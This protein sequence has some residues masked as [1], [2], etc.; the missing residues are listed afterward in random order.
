MVYALASLRPNFEPELAYCVSAD[1]E[2]E[3]AL[4]QSVIAREPGAEA[5]FVERYKKLIFG[6]ARK[7]FRSREED[8]KDVFQKTFVRLWE[9][10]HRAL[11]AWRGD[12]LFSTYLVTIVIHVCHEHLR[13]NSKPGPPEPMERV[14]PG[15]LPEAQVLSMERNQAVAKCWERLSAGDRLMLKYRLVDGLTPKQVAAL[16]GFTSGA[17]RKAIF[18]ARKRLKACLRRT[19]PDLFPERSNDNGG[20]RSNM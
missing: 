7:Q 10:D 16:R 13:R 15:E 14:D 1:K 5:R 6:T 20:E 19:Q 9:H 8:V 18:D 11:R 17:A 12:G 4:L 2:S 3:A